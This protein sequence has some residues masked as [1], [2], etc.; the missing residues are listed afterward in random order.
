LKVAQGN[1]EPVDV[2]DMRLDEAVQLIRG[3]K[4]S[5]VKLTIKKRD[6]AL[7]VVD[8]VRD[9]VNVEETFAK[10]AVMEL[11][12]EKY[13]YVYLPK[14][15]ADFDHKD[16]RSCAT[17][18]EIELKSLIADGVM[19]IVLDLRNNGGGSLQDVVDMTGL[20]IRTG[21]VVQVKSREATA[22][23]M[24]DTNPKQIWNGGLVILVNEMSASAS[25]IIAAAI[26]DYGRGIIMGSST[27]G[28]GTVQ[29]FLSFDDV[30]GDNYSQL[31]PL[32]A[33]K[34]TTQKFYRIN[35]STTQLKGVEPDVLLPDAYT[36]IPVGEKEQENALP[37]DVISATAYQQY[38]PEGYSLKKVIAQMQSD[39]KK[40]TNFR[41]ID[42]GAQFFKKRKDDTSMT[43]NYEDYKE[44][45][46][47][48][49]KTTKKLQI[50]TDFNNH[51][52]FSAPTKDKLAATDTMQQNERNMWFKNLKKDPYLEQAVRAL[53]LMK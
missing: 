53:Q 40:N 14:F 3:P 24:S 20:F 36:Y 17:D 21:P 27:F 11:E 39:L 4:G 12:N 46:N 22:K 10:S 15:Y 2:V 43:L 50:P 6:G 30:I 13:G 23:V 44:Q 47:E 9:V 45:M 19:G 1:A 31:K 5:V 42:K 49:D 18:V 34:L 35:G 7:I 41:N 16:G 32:G 51:I 52:L 48:A 29:R 38:Q 26:Q 37:W 33:M 8:L 25:E 28:K